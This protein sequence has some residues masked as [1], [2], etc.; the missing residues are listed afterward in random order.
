MIRAKSGMWTAGAAALFALL[1]GAATPVAAS[2]GH[3]PWD[4]D[5]LPAAGQDIVER[6]ER[7]WRAS[8]PA[9]EMAILSRRLDAHTAGLDRLQS[10]L[11]DA[12]DDADDD[13]RAMLEEDIIRRKSQYLDD[14]HNWQSLRSRELSTK[15]AQYRRALTRATRSKAAEPDAS[16]FMMPLADVDLDPAR[17]G[18][19]ADRFAVNQAQLQALAEHIGRARDAS[20]PAAG[21]AH[22]DRLGQVR[23]AL[24]AITVDYLILNQEIRMTRLM[25][26]L[27]AL[28]A[29]QLMGQ[30]AGGSD[31]SVRQSVQT[32]ALRPKAELF[33]A[34]DTPR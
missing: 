10:E 3:M 20:M 14:L 18:G 15:A 27:L 17:M 26:R 16:P 25:G 7:A 8:T 4:D 22:S 11:A 21:P 12:D 19:L 2:D 29:Q 1:V 24:G 13:A 34:P 9:Q 30:V 28:D 31:M 23:L 33:L 5:V 6:V 32:T